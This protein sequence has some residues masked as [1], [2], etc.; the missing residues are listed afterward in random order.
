MEAPGL[1]PKQALFVREYLVDLSATA[2]AIR[3]GYSKKTAHSQGPRLL[4]NVGVAAAIQKAMNKRAEKVELTAERVLEEIS[5]IGFTELMPP[6]KGEE[7]GLEWPV[8]RASDKLKALELLGKHLKL[9]TEK[10]ELAHSFDMLTDEQLQAR[11]NVLLEKA[12]PTSEPIPEPDAGEP[13][14]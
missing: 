12:A 11:L 9:F 6:M 5:A 4:A 2:A 1:T 13:S 14:V 10:H 7:G 3:A 8:V